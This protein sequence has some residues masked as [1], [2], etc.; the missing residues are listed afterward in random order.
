MK[1]TAVTDINPEPLVIP[2]IY[3]FRYFASCI[4]I[5]FGRRK[6][7]NMS[8]NLKKS[9]QLYTEISYSSTLT[10]LQFSC[11]LNSLSTTNMDDIVFRTVGEYS[12]NHSSGKLS[13]L[14]F[15]KT[16]HNFTLKI[17]LTLQNYFERPTAPNHNLINELMTFT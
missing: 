17:N 14:L 4:R 6:N 7:E 13:S 15:K 12:F 10:P 11:T 9:L 16:F 5:V 2:K 1:I 3:F 8:K